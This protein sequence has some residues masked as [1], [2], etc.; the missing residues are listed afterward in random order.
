MRPEEE[1]GCP[2]GFRMFVQLFEGGKGPTAMFAGAAS[3]D[4][5]VLQPPSST[6]DAFCAFAHVLPPDEYVRFSGKHVGA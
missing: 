5:G 3:G 4:G 2:F 6:T 1:A